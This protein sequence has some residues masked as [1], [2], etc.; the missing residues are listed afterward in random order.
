MI[1]LLHGDNIVASRNYLNQ[2]VDKE[3]LK[4][5]QDI[6]RLNGE[7]IALEDVKQALESQSLFGSDRLVIVEN[8]FSRKKSKEKEII[9][10]YLKQSEINNKLIIW[11][12]KSVHPSTIR[13]LASKFTVRVF[14]LDPKIFKFLDAISPKNTKQMLILLQQVKK[15]DEAELIFYLLHRRISDLIVAKDLRGRGFEKRQNWQISRLLNQSSRFSME[16]LI[17]LHNKLYETDYQIKTGKN[18]LPLASLL[19]LIIADI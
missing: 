16:Q 2:I 15:T 1:T 8:I 12:P 6:E 11:E 13:G 7:T 10:K 17:S 19:D 4:G 3:K 14:K 18:V 9:T 5:I